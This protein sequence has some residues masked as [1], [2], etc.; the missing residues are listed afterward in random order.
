MLDR[1]G[2]I[3]R[4]RARLREFFKKPWWVG[5]LAAGVAVSHPH[6]DKPATAVDLSEQRITVSGTLPRYGSVVVV[7]ECPP[8]RHL[9]GGGY[10]LPSTLS[11][12]SSSRADGTNAWR[13]AFR[14][15]GGSG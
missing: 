2:C 6:A 12:A 11:R 14:R 5:P 1:W 7:A 8:G 10:T 13:V 15:L 9:S 4:T 3:A